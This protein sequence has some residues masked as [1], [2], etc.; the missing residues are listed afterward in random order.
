MCLFR[1]IPA[2]IKLYA[3]AIS[4]H[5]SKKVL[6]D[7]ITKSLEPSTN[8]AEVICDKYIEYNE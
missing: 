8:V 2:R 4:M 6:A 5:F 7:F 3:T 1:I